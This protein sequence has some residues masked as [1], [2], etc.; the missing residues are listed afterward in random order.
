M[1]SRSSMMTMVAGV[2]AMSLNAET[3]NQGWANNGSINKKT[4]LAKAKKKKLKQVKA[5][6]RRNR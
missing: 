1:V 4:K 2:A 5:S 6:R 3:Y